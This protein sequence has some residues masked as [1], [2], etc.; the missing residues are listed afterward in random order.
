ML[1]VVVRFVLS[2]LVLIV[3]GILVPG[4]RV[5]GFLAALAA[6]AVIALLGWAVQA[7]FGRRISPQGRGLTSFLVSAAII[8]LTQF[9]IPGF[10]AT[11][12]GALLAALVIGV[13]DAV[14]PTE[15]R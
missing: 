13:L 11:L 12:I 7:A 8:Y 9:L 10:R 6:A 5:G 3:T 4:F 15:L 14:I 1:G 2:A